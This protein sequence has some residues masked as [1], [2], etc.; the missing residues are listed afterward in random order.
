[1]ENPLPHVLTKVGNHEVKNKWRDA[2]DSIYYH[3][4]KGR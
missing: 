4:L 3:H 1:M 2:R